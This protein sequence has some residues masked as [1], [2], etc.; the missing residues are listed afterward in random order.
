MKR[1]WAA[2]RATEELPGWISHSL[3]PGEVTVSNLH[4]IPQTTIT[5]H[6][7][8]KAHLLPLVETWRESTKLRVSSFL[9]RDG[10]HRSC[11][12]SAK[13]TFGWWQLSTLSLSLQ[14]A[15]LDSNTENTPWVDGNGSISDVCAYLVANYFQ[16][17]LEMQLNKT[18]SALTQVKSEGKKKWLLD[19]H[20]NVIFLI[21][22]NK[23]FSWTLI[24]D[25][26]TS[27]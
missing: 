20:L 5:W 24:S 19:E 21:N 27:K 14:W 7:R 15:V 10:A 11:S 18:G 6:V 1:K 22:L 25:S 13:W 8:L 23:L 17:L 16:Q 3:W 2:N 12:L 4:K 26:S 9:C